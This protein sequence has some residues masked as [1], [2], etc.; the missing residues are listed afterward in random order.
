MDIHT[1]IEAWI[2]AQ[3]KI[4]EQAEFDA[5]TFTNLDLAF[6]AMEMGGTA[7]CALNAAN[8]VAVD[9]F[10]KEKIGFLDIARI[11]EAVLIEINHFSAPSYDNF[12]EVDRLAR[13]KSLKYVDFL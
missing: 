11:N 3:K 7:A 5:L 2:A 6:K 10:L 12:V 9:L 13:E 1:Q 8:E 4:E